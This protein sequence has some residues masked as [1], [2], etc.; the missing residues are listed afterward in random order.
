MS[1]KN[2][3]QFLRQIIEVFGR[4]QEPGEPPLESLPPSQRLV[5]NA[6]LNEVE[7]DVIFRADCRFYAIRKAALNDPTYHSHHYLCFVPQPGSLFAPSK[8]LGKSGSP[9]V[10]VDGDSEHRSNDG[11]VG[12]TETAEED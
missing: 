4:R 7:W 12:E 10:N 8:K 6:P 3:E 1:D 5:P 11:S 2:D 9:N